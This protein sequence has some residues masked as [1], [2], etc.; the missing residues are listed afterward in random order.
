[1]RGQVGSRILK[2][3]F[4][5]KLSKSF[6]IG[7]A[8]PSPPLG[9]GRARIAK[10][11]LVEDVSMSENQQAT[12]VQGQVAAP[13]AGLRKKKKVEGRK[14][15]VQKLKTDREFAKTYFEGKSKR[16]TEKKSAYRKKK[17]RKK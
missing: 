4:L 10:F 17:N 8:L 12:P 13:K 2:N 3:Q 5:I 9:G 7:N 6:T 1:V 14:K 16:S 15:R 11:I